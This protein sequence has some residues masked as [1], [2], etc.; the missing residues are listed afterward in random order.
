MV[1]EI[2]YESTRQHSYCESF[3][4]LRFEDDQIT[5]AT[6]NVGDL[7]IVR[8]NGMMPTR[9]GRLSPYHLYQIF[10]IFINLYKTDV[11]NWIRN[12]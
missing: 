2:V 9:Y 5:C 1:K 4:C 11:P 6:Q 3:R 10:F 7:T 12:S 8:C